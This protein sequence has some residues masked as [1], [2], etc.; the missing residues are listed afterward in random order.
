LVHTL[1][2]A[3]TGIPELLVLRPDAFD[4]LFFFDGLLAPI[5][6]LLL[7]GLFDDGLLPVFGEGAAIVYGRIQ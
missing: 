2:L 6:D 5:F 7:E 3:I 1:C 4:G